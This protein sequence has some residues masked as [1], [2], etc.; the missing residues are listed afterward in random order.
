MI[1]ID[2]KEGLHLSTTTNKKIKSPTKERLNKTAP[3]F[4]DNVLGTLLPYEYNIN[5]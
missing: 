2:S 3:S 5:V 4:S 1:S